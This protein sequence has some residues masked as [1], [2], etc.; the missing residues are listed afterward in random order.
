METLLNFLSRV[1]FRLFG[2]K[3]LRPYEQLILDAWRR[4]LAPMWQRVL[5]DQLQ[6]I[7][8]IQRQAGDAKVCI[9][10]SNDSEIALF[11]DASPNLN[12]AVIKISSIGVVEKQPLCV[13][14]YTHRGRFFSIE[15]PKR[16]Y[17]YA[18][19]HS[20]RLDEIIILNVE[21]TASGKSMLHDL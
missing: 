16:P 8:F 12:V 3:Q 20:M 19:L 17:R 11:S 5:D 13:K 14:I 21:I 7:Q 10:Y 4:N 18:Q 6:K 1:Y 9:Y 15:F 2:S